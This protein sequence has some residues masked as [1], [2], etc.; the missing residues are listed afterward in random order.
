MRN[1]KRK[2]ITYITC[3]VCGKKMDTGMCY[4]KLGRWLKA[5]FIK[6]KHWH[7]KAEILGKKMK[8]RGPIIQWRKVKQ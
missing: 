8:I 3:K 6:R 1:I 4:T 5:K 7:T 2:H